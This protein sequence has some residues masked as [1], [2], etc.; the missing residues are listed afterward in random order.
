MDRLSDRQ[1]LWA[2][3]FK[4]H[5]KC[6]PLREELQSGLV[7]PYSW[8]QIVLMVLIQAG[9]RSEKERLQNPGP[10]GFQRGISKWTGLI[11][12]P[13]NKSPSSQGHIGRE[14]QKILG[15]LDLR[16]GP[17]LFLNMKSPYG[18]DSSWTQRGISKWTGPVFGQKS[19]CGHNLR[20]VHVGKRETPKYWVSYYLERDF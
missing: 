18:F 17:I 13:D 19:P 20:Q 4:E 2:R 5:Q 9:T 15:K 14:T 1:C 12:F 16:E 6:L 10:V 8:T 3:L 11:Q 7:K